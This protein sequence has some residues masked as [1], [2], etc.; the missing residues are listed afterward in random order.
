[1]RLRKTYLRQNLVIEKE[2][3]ENAVVFILKN[4]C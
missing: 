3:R 1:M 4:G 2:D